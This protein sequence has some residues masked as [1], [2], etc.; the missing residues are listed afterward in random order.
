MDTD[1]YMPAFC[2]ATAFVLSQ[3]Q[4]TGLDVFLS[5]LETAAKAKGNPTHDTETEI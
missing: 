5:N 3:C 4:A 1:I 2:H